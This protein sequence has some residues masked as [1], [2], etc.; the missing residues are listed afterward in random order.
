MRRGRAAPSRKIDGVVRRRRTSCLLA[1][2]GACAVLVGACAIYDAS[3]LLP[4]TDGGIASTTDSGAGDADVGDGAVDTCAHK[5]PPSKPTTEDGTADLDFVMAGNHLRIIPAG[6]ASFAHPSSP[7]G[8][9]LDG[10]CTCPAAESCTPL[11]AT[12]HCDGEGG[13]DD[14]AGKIFQS[15]AALAPN[16][17]SDDAFNNN[18]ND[19]LGTI[20]VRIRSYNGGLDD[21]QV[22]V[23]LYGSNGIDGIQD[24]GKVRTP[25]K[26][27][28]TDVWTVDPTSLVGG[29]S[30]DGGPTCEGNDNVC[31]PFYADTEAYVANG[32]V[33]AHIDFPVSI[34]SADSLFVLKLS[35]TVMTA[36]LVPDDGGLFRID[37][38]QLVGRWNTAAFLTSL[39]TIHDPLNRQVFLCGDSGT[40]TNVK[41]LAC[42]G[43]DVMTSPAAD[44]TGQ[45]CDALSIAMSF[46]TVRAHIGPIY[47]PRA[48]A[49]G[50]G[51]S[52]KDDCS[53]FK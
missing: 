50:C 20:L 44:N 41:S 27:D 8:Y 28:G 4:A 6:R 52:W 26:F 9:D 45:P 38:G 10:V 46:S 19:G 40:Y 14:S 24:G 32:V 16:N 51:S 21:K 47:N 31:V 42:K 11:A 43:S 29:L 36:P 3:L 2:F 12:S 53:S 7:V 33:V 39:Q 34:G 22:T 30:L 5:R 23:I 13:T 17:F 49:L 35:D 25:P 1:A 18:V 15:F 37:E 48:V